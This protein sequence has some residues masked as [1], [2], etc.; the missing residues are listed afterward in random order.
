MLN[1]DIC[2]QTAATASQ[3][4]RDTILPD[5]VNIAHFG[6]F[7]TQ[8]FDIFRHNNFTCTERA[9]V[10]IVCCDVMQFD[11]VCYTVIAD[12]PWNY[13]CTIQNPAVHLSGAR[14]RLSPTLVPRLYGLLETTVISS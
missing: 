12:A 11:R 8:L 13:I 2:K 3:V 1:N 4:H 9:S 10:E 14:I 5:Q 7:E 6:Y